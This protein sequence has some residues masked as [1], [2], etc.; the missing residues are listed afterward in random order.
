MQIHNL[1]SAFQEVVNDVPVDTED[2]DA[3]MDNCFLENRHALL[4][5][6]QGNHYQFDSL[7]RAKHS[8][9]MI[10]YHL[11]HPNGSNAG[12]SCGLCLKDIIS[13]DPRWMCEICPEFNVCSSCYE[14]RGAFCHNHT[15]MHHPSTAIRKTEVKMEELV[16]SACIVLSF[17]LGED[18]SQ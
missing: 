1:T 9:M 6:C 5:F 7:R 14:K 12:T 13:A 2:N 15:L 17:F 3:I 16:R 4:S 10:L 8:S 18:G 11:H